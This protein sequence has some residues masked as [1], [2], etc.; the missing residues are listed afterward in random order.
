MHHA[1]EESQEVYTRATAREALAALNAAAQRLRNKH[2][3][4]RF[5]PSRE[6]GIELSE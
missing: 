3:G 6:S 4:T 1:S 5:V 2:A